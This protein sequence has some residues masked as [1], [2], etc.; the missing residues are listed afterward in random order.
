MQWYALDALDQLVTIPEPDRTCTGAISQDPREKF[1]ALCVFLEREGQELNA[2]FK[3]H[4]LVL[5]TRLGSGF[6][7][8]TRVFYHFIKF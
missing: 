5:I 1:E 4:S 8:L 7:P 3:D 6:D 2:G